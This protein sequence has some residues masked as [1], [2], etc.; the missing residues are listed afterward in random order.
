MSNLILPIKLMCNAEGFWLASSYP[1]VNNEVGSEVYA[2]AGEA[3][4][5]LLERM[6]IESVTGAMI[7]MENGDA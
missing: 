7:I 3:I 6:G 4:E 1:A 5:S 2:S